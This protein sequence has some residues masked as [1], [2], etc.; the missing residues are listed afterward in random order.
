MWYYDT[1]IGRIHIK[2][3]NGKYYFV[4]KGEVY[5]GHVS[6]RVVADDIYSFVTG[7]NE[8]DFYESETDYSDVPSDLSEWH[9]TN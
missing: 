1:N 5:T 8:W 6:A 9:R 4:F 2:P 7:C 3:I